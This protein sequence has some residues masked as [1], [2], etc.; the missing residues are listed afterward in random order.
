MPVFLE[1]I[2]NWAHAFFGT[3]F[4][5]CTGMSVLILIGELIWYRIRRKRGGRT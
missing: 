2:F 1:S 3:A 5:A 4:L